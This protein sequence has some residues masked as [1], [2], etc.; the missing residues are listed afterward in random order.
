MLLPMTLI[1]IEL[2]TCIFNKGNCDTKHLN[3]IWFSTLFIFTHKP[4]IERVDSFYQAYTMPVLWIHRSDASDILV[5]FSEARKDDAITFAHNFIYEV[6]GGY[7]FTQS[8]PMDSHGLRKLGSS[9]SIQIILASSDEF[10]P[11]DY[12]LDGNVQA[13]WNPR[14]FVQ[15]AEDEARDLGEAGEP[16]GFVPYSSQSIW[17]QDYRTQDE[18]NAELDA[19]YGRGSNE[20]IV[21]EN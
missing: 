17:R 16:E 1:Y 20:M 21:D 7:C 4:K 6:S 5:Q 3:I 2:L 19:Y 18:L 10:H 12:H 13:T 8:G 15:V 9:A 11:N 14:G